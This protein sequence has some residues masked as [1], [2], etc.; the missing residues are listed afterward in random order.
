MTPRR[1]LGAIILVSAALRL[2]WAASLG[3]GNDE[4]YYYLFTRHR[5]WSYFD[6]PPMLEVVES[7]GLTLAGGYTTPLTLRLGFVLL[8]SVSTFLMARLTARFY[9]PWSG[10]YA[11][12]LLTVS[13][14]FGLA[15]SAFA[16]PDGPLLFFWLLSLDRLA[17]ALSAPPRTLPWVAVGLAWGGAMLSKYHAVFLPAGVALYFILEPNARFWLRR[18]EPYLA[19]AVGILVFSP[20]L[21]WNARHGWASFAF[22]G[23]RALGEVVPR[24]GN[25]LAAIGGQALYLFPWIWLPLVAVLAR[26]IRSALRGDA[27]GPY[28]FLASQAAIP[29]AVFLVVA[30]FRPVLP[31]WSAAGYVVLFPILGHAWAERAKLDPRAIRRRAA[32]FAVIPLGL[33]ATSLLQAR[34]G[35]FQEGRRGHLALLAV[36]QD[37]TV[38]LYGWGEIAAELRRRGLIGAPN[39]FLFTSKW[40]YSGQLAFALRD[41]VPVLCYSSTAPH[42]FGFWSRPEDWVGQ[43]GILVVVDHSSTEPA[44]YDRWFERIESLGGFEV[45]RAGSPVR[46]VRLYRCVNQRKPFPFDRPEPSQKMTARR[47]S[48]A[49][50]FPATA[51]LP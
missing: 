7:L 30:C 8:F 45:L 36:S 24:P 35:V 27:A 50:A 41:R 43:D 4:A 13:G 21:L 20:A 31:H 10:V 19:L 17:A 9:T 26:G 6:H 32:I 5:D 1:A 46:R 48:P 42:G 28:R 47:G 25:L 34:L 23:G 39:T 38:D 49:P 22:Q 51:A 2:V 14:Y 3:A 11:A 15:A 16:L 37:P 18:I 33:A 29:L 40:Y 12:L 44:A